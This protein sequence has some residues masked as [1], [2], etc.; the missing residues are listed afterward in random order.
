MGIVCNESLAQNA[1]QHS[2][3][4]SETQQVYFAPGNLQYQAST[5]TWRFAINPWDYV[6]DANSNISQTYGGW[7]DLFCW[8]TSGYDHGATCYQPWSTCTASSYFA[9]GN[10]NYNLNDQTGKADWG[11][12]AISNGGNTINTWRTPTV[13]EWGYVFNTRI[14]SSGIR[15]AKAKVNNINGVVLLPDDWSNSYYSLSSTNTSNASYNANTISSTQWAA[16]EQHGA[17]FLPAAGRRGMAYTYGS[18][19]YYWSASHLNYEAYDVTFD[20]SRLNA[21]SYMYRSDGLSV[22]LILSCQS[23][24]FEIGAT[25]SPTEGGAVS[26]EGTYEAGAECTLTATASAGY[27]FAGWSSENEEF[28]SNEAVYSFP[29]LRNRNL[30]ANF[31][32]EG[33]IEFADANVKSV[34]LANWDSNDDGELSYAE[35]SVVTSIGEEFKNNNTIQ[36]FNELSYF[37][38]LRVIGE[39]AFYGCTSLSQITIP[40]NVTTVGNKAFWNCPALQTVYFNAIDCVMQSQSGYSVFSS[41]TNGGASAITRVVFGSEVTRIPDYAFK[42]SQDIYQRLVIPA[43]VIEIGKEA[44]SGCEG[45]A[46]M[47]IQGN[48]LQNIG[49]GAFYNCSSMRS[50]LQLPSSLS[51]IGNNAFYNCSSLA[52]VYYNGNIDQ[53]CGISFGNE[54]SNPLLYGHNLY[55]NNNLLTNLLLPAGLTSIPNY[56]FTG[57]TCLSGELVIP[58]SV[59]AIGKYAFNGCIGLTGALIIPDAVTT[60]DYSAFNG[61]VGLTGELII[62]NA[63]TSL[64]SRA[65][66]EC[67]GLTSL[68][69]GEEVTSIGDSTFFNCRGLAGELVIPDAVTAIGKSAFYGC[70][71]LTTLT[72]G[73][74]VTIIDEFAFWKCSALATVHFNATNCTQMYSYYNRQ[75]HSVFTTNEWATPSVTPIVTLSIGDN[76]TRIPDYA[77]YSSPNLTGSLL[78]P[79]ALTYVG[80]HAFFRCSGLSGNLSIPSSVTTFGEAAFCQ[81]SGFT[82]TLILGKLVNT[83]GQNAF[84]SCSGLTTIILESPTPPSTNSTYTFWGI[85]PSIPVYVPFNTVS[86]YQSATGWSYFTN[87]KEQCVFDAIGMQNDNWSD[88]SNWYAGALPTETDVVC[89]NSNCHLDM[90]ATV[91]HLYV[92]NLNDTFTIDNDATLT[93]SNGIGTM[94]PSQLIIDDGGQLVNMSG[95]FNGTVLKHI[96]GYGSDTEGW[97][98]LASPLKD[99][100]DAS[101]VSLGEYDLFAYDEPAHYWRNQKIA[102]NGIDRL[103]PGHGYLYANQADTVLCFAGK[104]NTSNAEVN[105]QVTYEGTPFEGYTLVGNPYTNNISIGDVQ[106]NGTPLTTYYKINGGGSLVA[107]SD[108]EPIRPGEGFLVMA[109]EGGT[110]TFAP[111]LGQ[112]RN[113]NAIVL[114]DGEEPEGSFRLPEH[115]DMVDVDAYSGELQYVGIVAAVNEAEYGTVQGAGNYA[116]GST[117]TLTAVPAEMYAFVSWTC[118]GA[119]VSTNPSYTF[120]V[121]GPGS[122]TANFVQ[123]IFTQASPLTSGWNWWSTY[124]DQNNNNGLAMLENTLGDHGLRIVSHKNGFVEPYEAN[125]V[126]TWY[127][128]LNGISNEQM[129]KVLTDASISTSITGPIASPEEH[130]I[131]INSGWNWIGYPSNQCATVNEALAG[132]EAEEDDL[133]KSYNSSAVYSGGSWF[134]SLQ[135]LTPG[136]G[137]MFKSNSATPKTLVFQQGRGQ[138]VATVELSHPL[139]SSTKR[140]KDNMTIV[141]IVDMDGVDL[142]STNAELAAYVGE[143]CRGSIKLMYVE[144][145]DRYVAFLTI[146]G[147]DTDLINF[148]L[149]EGENHLLSNNTVTF[150]P[151]AVLG[152]LRN[153][154][155]ISFGNLNVDENAHEVTKV[156]PNPVM[157]ELFVEGVGMKRVEVFNVMGQRVAAADVDDWFMRIDMSGCAKGVYLVRVLTENGTITHHIVKE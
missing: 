133:I 62:P 47:T 30:V 93:V 29:V 61:C 98:T 50:D 96:A 102:E 52:A 57:G 59:T 46:L 150:E 69:I 58:N 144:P 43:S 111:A 104:L 21:D 143:E 88:E 74:G 152:T 155:R 126:I 68:T 54:Y 94:A 25:P 60:I 45:L 110:I 127:G 11:Y 19:G 108:A 92:F 146:L 75:Y 39:Q 63:V 9:Y 6:G 99:G 116:V 55:I 48:S 106:L 121:M 56:V 114:R 145:I 109:P 112:G 14:T 119:I 129:Y 81:C 12:N 125:G 70:S 140:F 138:D 115:S 147:E 95:A 15:Y 35:T 32:T 40:E 4:V 148:V 134:G 124:L 5:N 27:E 105:V 41:N 2:F 20:D 91:R 83:I 28:V 13:E 34:C 1:P 131:T 103:M 16:L 101:D 156:F 128:T 153:P 84:Q 42:G 117:C 137:Y 118:N 122:Y 73:E 78:L 142:Q 132:F 135:S 141:A 49:E 36:S 3:S 120:T 67:V 100:L 17:V 33:Y 44:F 86:T 64:G 107:Y 23:C 80:T 8:G 130:P 82:G 38:N 139:E 151:D 89:V 31:L 87:Y 97:F 22:R 65:F 71:G 113:D 66:N 10:R 53:W 26:G 7:I 51:S 37:V 24:S 85:D 136:V 76:V 90:D 149:V 157:Q 72:I 18:D 79:D 123:S 77:F 154:I